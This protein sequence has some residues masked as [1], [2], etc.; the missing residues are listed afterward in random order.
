MKVALLGVGLMGLP[1]VKNLAKA[2]HTVHIWNRSLEKITSLSSI[3][4]VHTTAADAV[5]DTDITICMLSDGIVTSEV[6]VNNNVLESC[7]ANSLIINM[8]S[9]EPERDKGHA[10]MARSIGKRFLD[11]PVSGGVKG[12]EDASLSIFVGGFQADMNYA[13][14]VLSALGKPHY[15]GPNGTGQSAKL[16]NQLIVAITIGAVAEAFKLAEA[17]GC[18]LGVLQKALQGGFADSRILIQH[19]ERMVNGDYAPG[20]RSRTQLKDIHNARQVADAI[21]L[22]LPLAQ[23]AQA[24]FQSLVD[25]YDGG[26]LDHSAY[27]LWLKKRQD[28]Q[29]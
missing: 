17:S 23:T 19:G 16:A 15:L 12:A 9:V 5:A 27:Y 25:E 24:G 3:A 11:A 21:S 20:A 1:M 18:D 2:G 10:E 22:D 14:P 7:K 28:K 13:M 26:D 29:N 8:G 4:T 6:L